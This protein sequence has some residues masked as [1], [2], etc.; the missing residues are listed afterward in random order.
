M[1]ETNFNARIIDLKYHI[2][3]LVPTNVCNAFIEFFEYV[4]RN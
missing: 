2:N 4:G 3:G 1:K